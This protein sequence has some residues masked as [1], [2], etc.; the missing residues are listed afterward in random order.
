MCVTIHCSNFWFKVILIHPGLTVIT[1]LRWEKT[2]LSYLYTIGA[3][4]TK[5]VTEKHIVG[6]LFNTINDLLLQRPTLTQKNERLG[7]VE[8]SVPT[9][10]KYVLI[11][12]TN[13]DITERLPRVPVIII[14]TRRTGDGG[15]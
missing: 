5:S 14:I 13:V 3:T 12:E 4:V 2:N 9:V 15:P 8:M 7:S 6:L 11:E 1:D 10:Q